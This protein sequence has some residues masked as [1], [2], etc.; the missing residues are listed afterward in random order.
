MD[1]DSQSTLASVNVEDLTDN[2]IV[3]V[4]VD[5]ELED[6]ANFTMDASTFNI[7]QGNFTVDVATG[8]MYT[9]AETL[10]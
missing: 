10:M 3:I 9:S 8:N 2:R 1:V 6:D 7:G 5:G 4:G